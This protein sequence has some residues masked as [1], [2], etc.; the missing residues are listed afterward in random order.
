ME[1]VTSVQGRRL[2]VP[3]VEMVEEPVTQPVISVEL[4]LFVQNLQ[5]ET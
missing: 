5:L 1:L 2:V 4:Q 3:L